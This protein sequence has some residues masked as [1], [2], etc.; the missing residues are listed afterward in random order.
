MVYYDNY[1]SGTLN[2][3]VREE[4]AIDQSVVDSIRHH[5]DELGYPE[6]SF[7]E[8]FGRAPL[9]R[10]LVIAKT[11]IRTHVL[12]HNDGIPTRKSL[13]RKV[14]AKWMTDG[15]RRRFMEAQNHRCVYCF[16]PFDT[17]RVLGARYPTWE[18]VEE[19]KLG[20]FS[21]MRNIV[22]ACRT[23]NGLRDTLKLTAHD[24]AD[25]ARMNRSSIDDAARRSE[26]A[27]EIKM[28]N[29]GEAHL[30]RIWGRKRPLFAHDV[31]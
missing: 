25:W 6:I 4:A 9:E 21:Q 7:S 29:K 27:L 5:L 3:V 17:K 11:L 22:I 12:N 23:C 2:K 13:G 24:Y 30:N 26:H 14:K 28:R 18:H 20:G 15:N 10:S 19:V 16:E 1:V 31:D 8:N